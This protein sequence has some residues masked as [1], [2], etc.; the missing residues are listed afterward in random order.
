MIG[1]ELDVFFWIEELSRGYVY[2]VV[3]H[4]TVCKTNFNSSILSLSCSFSRLL[5]S[6]G[7]FM[8]VCSD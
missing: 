8:S 1:E 3:I 4:D 7:F 2:F 6:T 5:E